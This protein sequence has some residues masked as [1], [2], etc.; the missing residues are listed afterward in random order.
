MTDHTFCRRS[1]RK[2]RRPATAGLPSSGLANDLDPIRLQPDSEARNAALCGFGWCLRMR[3]GTRNIDETPKVV[4]EVFGC[5]VQ[6][7]VRLQVFDFLTHLLRSVLHH[8]AQIVRGKQEPLAFGDSSENAPSDPSA[9]FFNE[10]DI[11][12]MWLRINGVLRQRAAITTATRDPSIP[13]MARMASR[14]KTE[15]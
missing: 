7:P 14:L 9:F 2:G 1:T 10:A 15:R 11:E 3:V 8:S 4:L 13:A 6:Q 5:R 12:R